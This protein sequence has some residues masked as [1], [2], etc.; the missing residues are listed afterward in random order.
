M[1]SSTLKLGLLTCLILSSQPV[2]AQALPTPDNSKLTEQLFLSRE[3]KEFAV[4]LNKAKKAK[5]PPQQIFEAEFLFAVDANNDVLIASLLPR[6][7]KLAPL[8][9]TSGSAIFASKDDFLAVQEFIKGMSALQK[10]QHDAFQQHLKQAFWLSPGIAP[11]L[12]KSIERFKISKLKET[13]TLP[14]QHLFLDQLSGETN[15]FKELVKGHNGLVIYFYNPWSRGAVA[16]SDQ[17]V[18]LHALCKKN[19]WLHLQYNIETNPDASEDSTDYLKKVKQNNA[20]HW[21]KEIVKQSLVGTFRIKKSPIIVHL[22]PQ[23]KII[24]HGS[25]KK[26][27]GTKR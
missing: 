6:V 20:D 2:V 22:S 5:L 26:F 14:L 15:T 17:I 21:T 10:K 7:N 25:L 24:F 18:S 12:E 16:E 1:I 8:F 11:V 3:P 13:Y 19:K 23:G 4:L 27:V 9:K